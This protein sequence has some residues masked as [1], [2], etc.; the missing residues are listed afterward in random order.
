MTSADF[1]H[2]RRGISP[3]KSAFFPPMPAVSTQRAF[4]FRRS[5]HHNDVLAHPAHYASYTVPVRQYSRT[6]GTVS[7]PSGLRLPATPLRL[8][9]G[10]PL[11]SGTHKGLSPSRLLAYINAN[12]RHPCRTHTSISSGFCQLSFFIYFKTC[13]NSEI[14]PLYVLEM[15]KPLKCQTVKWLN[16][17]SLLSLKCKYIVII[18]EDQFI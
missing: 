5:G 10:F 3:G 15:A 14:S 17:S 1:P 6:C 13:I 9:N 18:L 7:L 12:Q 2:H 16:K 11:S 8:A 4:T